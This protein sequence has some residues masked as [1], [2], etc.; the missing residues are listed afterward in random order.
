MEKISYLGLPNCYRLTNGEIELVV[1]TD[2]GPRIIF[3][4]FAG[5]F[6]ILGEHPA[7]RVQTELGEFR[8]YG[9]HR[10][11]LAPENM[12]DSY[13]PDNEP[14]EFEFTG[15]LAV[16]LTQKLE[17]RSQTQKEIIVTLDEFNTSATILHRVTNHGENART[18]ALWALTIMREGGEAVIPNEPFAEYSPATLLPVRNLTLWSY[19]DL[20]DS[21][22]HFDHHQIRLEVDEKKTDPQKI[23]V[24]NKQGWAAYNWQDQKFVKRFDYVEGAAY[25]DM[26]S[27]TEL[28][29]AGNFVEVES[30]APLVTLQPGETT[31]Y[32]EYW[33]LQMISA[34]GY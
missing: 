9:G 17:P 11:W 26:N 10:L 13:A 34:A 2:V 33:E 15:E 18:L 5:G 23:G 12:P 6:N 32:T 22:W 14:V 27:N 30:L 29:T 25:P 1:T 7:E 24:L 19:T 8:P 16:R 3:Y 21:R 31:E 20:T 4:G 28:Y